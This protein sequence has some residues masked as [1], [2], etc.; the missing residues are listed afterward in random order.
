MTHA[1][2]ETQ[3]VVARLAARD[4]ASA[5][6]GVSAAVDDVAEAIRTPGGLTYDG[7]KDLRSR[8][9]AATSDLLTKTADKGDYDAVYGALTKDLQRA[10]SAAG[11]SQAPHASC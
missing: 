5:R 4:A 2:P 9:G 1:L 3:N 7:I 11:G 6:G 10:V 8:I